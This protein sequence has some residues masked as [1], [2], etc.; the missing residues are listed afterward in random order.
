MN[1]LS[2]NYIFL[3]RVLDSLFKLNMILKCWNVSPNEDEEEVH[4][5]AASRISSTPALT[6]EWGLR[7]MPMIN[8][9]LYQPNVAL[10]D[11]YVNIRGGRWWNLAL[12]Q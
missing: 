1:K 2:V 5:G 7:D 8:R 6:G 4:I 12:Y 10:H 9:Q 3:K 11:E